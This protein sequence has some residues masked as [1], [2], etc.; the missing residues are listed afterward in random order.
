M[1]KYLISVFVP[2]IEMKFEL[3][4]PNNKKVGTIK[5]H[6]LKCISILSDNTFNKSSEVVRMSDKENGKEYDNN[7]YIKDTNIKN[8]TK[9][10][11]M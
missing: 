6:I 1:N 7:L 5:N 11:I 3:Y 9:I 2:T 10:I 4:I 8:G